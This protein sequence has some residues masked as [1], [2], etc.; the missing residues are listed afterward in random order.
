MQI[1]RINSLLSK[2]VFTWTICFSMD[3]T[4]DTWKIFIKESVKDRWALQVNGTVINYEL[5]ATYTMFI[6]K[7]G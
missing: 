7:I 2:A 1:I 6:Q 5:Y 4:G 3:R